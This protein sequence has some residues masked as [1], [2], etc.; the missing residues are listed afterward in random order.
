M[1]FDWKIY[2][3]KPTTIVGYIDWL[4]FIYCITLGLYMLDP[5]ERKLFSEWFI[6]KIYYST[7]LLLYLDASS[8]MSLQPSLQCNLSTWRVTTK[9]TV[10]LI[11]FPDSVL[12]TLI[13]MSFYTAYAFLPQHIY[14]ML[15]HFGLL[16]SQVIQSST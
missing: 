8:M 9:L 4:Y 16:S 15:M 14:S 7:L 3:K 5:W 13:S 6:C 1:G 12:V 11:L 10:Y 2:G